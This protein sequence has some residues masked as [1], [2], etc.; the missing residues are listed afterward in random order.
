MRILVTGAAGFIGFYVAKFLLDRG[1]E[2]IGFDNLNDYYDVTLK[3]ARL[4][5]L[6]P[7]KGFTFIKGD[8]AD[9]ETVAGLFKQYKPS[10]V[11]HLAAQAGVRYSLENPEAYTRSNLVGFA[12]ILEACHNHD[13]EHLIYASSSS[14]YGA[15]KKIP[16][17]VEDRVDEPLNY[18]GATKRANELMAFSYSRL[19]G[20]NTT[21]LRFF[22][23]Y[24]PWGRPD[25]S[26]YKFTDNIV[27]G[28]PVD[29]YNNGD[30]SRDFTCIDDILDGVIKAMDR[31]P[32]GS[33]NKEQENFRL[34][35]L[36][37]NDPVK[38]M[39]YIAILE[40]LIGKKAIMNMLP[41]QPGDMPV[42][43]ADIDKTR[44]DLGYSPTTGIEQGLKTFVDW[45]ME[46]HEVSKCQKN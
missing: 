9:A 16:F 1:D 42:T 31:M 29:V 12:H 44:S 41:R 10:R 6:A 21:G 17:S 2:V 34:Y 32:A 35:N 11:V 37:N 19:F 5:Q 13:I 3:E 40:K 25:M 28:L 24:G 26:Y 45:Y 46:Y 38:L 18:Y 23:V 39:D 14:V 43:Y 22:T 27:K 30:H 15:N 8:L 7:Y 4:A 33:K 20:M 36:G